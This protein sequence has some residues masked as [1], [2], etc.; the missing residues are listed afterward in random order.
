MRVVSQ[1]HCSRRRLIEQGCRQ[2]R[3]GQDEKK[4]IFKP[5]YGTFEGAVLCP[6]EL[7]L[8]TVFDR[9]LRLF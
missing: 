6:S 5:K 7:Q 9:A 4:S 3:Q 2:R 1:A 8:F